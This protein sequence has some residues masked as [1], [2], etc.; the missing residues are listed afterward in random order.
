M[1]S[2]LAL[3]NE[4]SSRFHLKISREPSLHLEI[5]SFREPQS[6]E[7]GRRCA[8][9]IINYTRNGAY[10]TWEDLWVTVSN[11]RH[12]TKPILRGLT[13]HSRPGELVAVMGP[14]GCGK[15]TLLDALAGIRFAYIYTLIAHMRGA[16]YVD[17]LID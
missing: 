9:Q 13:G 4:S 5:E 8:D 15:S 6:G 7:P 12:G 2:L 10:I 17:E 14:S 11:G 3:M 1:A 16:F